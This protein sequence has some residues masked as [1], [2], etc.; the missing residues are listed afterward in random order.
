M[1]DDGISRVVIFI[2]LILASAILSAAE[3]AFINFNRTRMKNLYSM[4]SKKAALVLK[5][6]E[7]YEET[8]S[9]ILIINNITNITA[10]S[11]AVFTLSSYFNNY[12]IA[13]ATI[14]TILLILIFGELLPKVLAKIAPEKFA[15]F[16]APAIQALAFVCIPINFLL[17]SFKKGFVRIFGTES[18]PSVTEDELKTM[19]DEVENEG[20]I[21]KSE[22]DLIRS[23]IEFNETVVEDIYTPRIDIA[24]IEEKEN[25][26]DIKE[27][28]LLSGYS[29]LPVFRGDIDN[30]VGV[31]HEKDFYQALNRKEKDI[32]GLVSKILFVTPNKK[33]SELLKELQIAKAHMAIVIDEY[34]GTEG[35]VTMEDIIEELVGEI[36]DEHDEVIEW[37]KK[38]DDDKFLISC[39]ADIEDMFDLFG[40]EA[41][42]EMDVTTVNG[43]ITT[44]F[45]EIPE[46]GGRIAYKNLDITVTKAEAKR[47]LEIQVEKIK[48]EA[49]TIVQ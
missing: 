23:A 48:N 12:G 38:I 31:L 14:T 21:N 24:G 27:K 39:N 30:I 15:I 6:D 16:S 45:E 5:L 49:H 32:K 9:T 8:M 20:V 36:W 4:N 2:F 34:G 7:N 3:T 47:V 35:L 40:L 25:L 11:I 28:F 42:D 46:V 41:D 37:F 43:F 26:D 19:I 17:F 22:S 29:R 13:L 10:T 44:L 18:L 1:D 33:I